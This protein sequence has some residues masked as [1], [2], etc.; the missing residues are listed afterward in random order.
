MTRPE[1]LIA[2]AREKEEKE[3]VFRRRSLPPSFR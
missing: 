3:E 2:M 1:S